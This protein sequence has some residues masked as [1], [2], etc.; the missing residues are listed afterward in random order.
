MLHILRNK[1]FAFAQALY[2]PFSDITSDEPKQS[3]HR[4][5]LDGKYLKLILNW[6]FMLYFSFIPLYYVFDSI[7]ADLIT[8]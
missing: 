4:V 6:L 5:D 7:L 1:S 2:I 8:G 3:K